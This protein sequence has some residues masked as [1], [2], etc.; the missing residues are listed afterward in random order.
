M[1]ART[2]WF[3]FAAP[4]VLLLAGV[5]AVSAQNI[6]A[7]PASLSFAYQIGSVNP[8]AQTVQVTGT[9]GQMVTVTKQATP[10]GASDWL[11]FSSSSSLPFTMT[12]FVL[13]NSSF[14]AG[15]Y[16]AT[17][18]VTPGGG[19]TPA[20]IIPVTF[21][22]SANPLF[23]ALPASLVFQY[24]LNGAAPPNQTV[25]LGSSSIASLNFT[26]TPSVN[27]GGSWL[28]L[29]PPATGAT[30][31]TITAGVVVNNTFAVGTY[32]GKITLTST[33]TGN[34]TLDIPVTL[35]VTPETNLTAAPSSVSFTYQ[36][37]ASA[38]M[39]AALTVGSTGV[40]AGI[41]VTTEAQGGGAG[42]SWLSVSPTSGATPLNLSV[43][44]NP[45][46]LA[47]GDYT[48]RIVLTSP[49]ASNSPVKVPVTFKITDKPVV[50]LS[51]ASLTFHHQLGGGAPAGEVVMLTNSGAP[52]PAA[53]TVTTA[54]GGDWLSVTP[55]STQTPAAFLVSAEP[56]T[57]TAGEYAG[58]V[59]I[60]VPGA[61]V[62][63]LTLPVTLRVSAASSPLMRLS[64]RRVNFVYQTGQGAPAARTIGVSSTG[65]TVAYAVSTNVGTGGAWLSVGA[66]SGASPSDI[67][68]SVNPISLVAGVYSGTVTVTPNG[69]GGPAQ[70]VEVN[71]LVSDYPVLD[72]PNDPLRFSFATGG[73]AIPDKSIPVTATSGAMPF[74]VST[75]LMNGT[76]WLFVGPLSG[77]ATTTAQSLTVR[78]NNAAASGTY[79]G[80]VTV[81]ASNATGALSY[82]VPVLYTA[83]SS[84]TLQVSPASLRFT[85]PAGGQPPAPKTLTV[86]ST[87]NPLDFTTTVET[88]SNSGDWLS[89]SPA[90]GLTPRE[91]SVSIK[92][93]TLAAG[94]YTGTIRIT[95]A[96]TGA[97]QIVPVILEV[98]PAVSQLSATPAN[99]SFTHTAGGTA[100]QAQVVT[101]KSAVS[102]NF[103]ITTTTT[104]GGPWLSATPASGSG[105]SA[106]TVSVN[107]TGLAPGAYSGALVVTAP[108]VNN[109]PLQIPVTLTV[110]GPPAGNLT[111]F[112]NGAS[113]LA[114][115]AAPGLIVTL[116]GTGL[117]PSPGVSFNL[118]PQGSVPTTVGEARVW[119]DG[120]AAPVLYA[121]SSQINAVVPYEVYGRFSTK[122]DV[123]YRGVRSNQIDVRVADSA[124]GIFSLNSTGS[125]QGAVLNQNG[126][127]NNAGNAAARG[128][129]IVLYATGEGQTTPAGVSGSVPRSAP[130]LRKPLSQVKVRIGGVEVTPMYAGSAPGFVAGLMQINATVPDNITPGA[131]V[132]VEVIVGNTTSAAQSISV[133]IK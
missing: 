45:Q 89:V 71:L 132:P 92:T 16:T 30:P 33:S 119:F 65:A 22:V 17:I 31:A 13:A 35:I 8:T 121:S 115:P 87:G 111:T 15:V 103:A 57:L 68:V 100:P 107:V 128:E 24:A 19:S 76:G 77:S 20:L 64:R 36:Q 93:N 2:Q 52:M 42:P 49:G 10:I 40:A 5:Q 61:A 131:S 54:G 28:T 85:Q 70:S 133:A 82:H 83:S 80:L 120:V 60:A 108:G 118:T 125:G 130:E 101:V 69:V 4:A 43:T 98:P 62:T 94:D 116:R 56:G 124:P 3:H 129:V 122:V 99:L 46:G 117:G 51:A 41:A 44:A 112:Q 74:T 90:G 27:S 21:T 73:A 75:T 53:F 32:T 29:A 79:L 105:E 23:T 72:V 37:G 59:S 67:T 38:P 86:S 126:T 81:S 110:S 47:L 50:T 96:A 97:T 106:V 55:A 123:E 1:K 88:F 6:T 9:A 91:L 14:P 114:A 34:P 7:A 58:S 109:S 66:A 18:T 11:Y 63:P 102:V 48:A 25:S 39:P 12:V 84:S 113:F 127:V 26:A 95:S 78:A 104:S